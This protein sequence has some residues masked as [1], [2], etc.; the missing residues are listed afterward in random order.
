LLTAKKIQSKLKRID[1]LRRREAMHR[2]SAKRE[3]CNRI[4]ELVVGDIL[5]KV[6]EFEGQ[7]YIDPKSDLCIRVLADGFFEPELVTIATRAVDP[8]RD[9]IDVGANVGFYAI[10]L[11]RRLH[12]GRRVVAFEPATEAYG[13]LI[14]N[15]KHNEVEDRVVALPCAASNVAGSSALYR[16]SGRSE[17]SS[18]TPIVHPC[19][20]GGSVN[21]EHVP[22]ITVDEVVEQHGLRPAFIKVDVEGAEHLVL[23]GC[24]RT[25]QAH[26][27]VLLMEVSD[28]LLRASGSSAASLIDCVLSYDYVVADPVKPKLEPGRRAFG[29]I[30]CFPKENDQWRSLLPQ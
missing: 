12:P 16:V 4:K 21:P 20:L 13:N 1:P 15:V 26:R 28:Q 10:L 29:D 23:A 22:T 8:E 27:P 7:F 6:D 11:A 14:R 24:R 5:L 30:V 9:V 17:Y 18:L 2:R 3:V 19:A 25:I